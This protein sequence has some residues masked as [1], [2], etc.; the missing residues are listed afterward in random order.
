MK[1][2]WIPFIL[3]ILLIM[4]ALHEPAEASD[5]WRTQDMVTEI[6]YQAFHVYDHW[7]TR[8]ISSNCDEYEELNPLLGSCPS[9]RKVDQYFLA[10][11]L[12]HMGISY[13]LPH[14][15]REGW[16]YVTIGFEAG[17]VYANVQIGL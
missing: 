9:S 16:Q 13:T 7:Q 3:F 5:E 4:L 8:K 10:T 6:I 17:V 11:G 15:W 1:L 12:L 14:G 2:K